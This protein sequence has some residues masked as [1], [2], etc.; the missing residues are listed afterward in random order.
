M[1][2]P[3]PFFLWRHLNK[4]RWLSLSIVFAMLV[5]LPFMHVYQTFTA[6]HAYDLLAPAEK[7]LYDVMET[8]TGVF[9]EDPA[10]DLDAIKGNT[11]SGSFFG[12][13]LSDPLAI[14]GQMA[15]GLKLYAPFLLTAL[16]PVLFTLLLG[17]F[18]CGWICPENKS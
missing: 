3:T 14:A 16:I 18:F 8:L 15:A 10:E 6:A 1:G 5:A 7:Q 4:L 13:Q 2:T 11:W 17:R 12:L 9:T